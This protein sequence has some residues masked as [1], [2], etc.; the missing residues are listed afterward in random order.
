MVIFTWDRA[1]REILK[2]KVLGAQLSPRKKKQ[3]K[4]NPTRSDVEAAVA[5]FLADGGRIRKVE[6]FVAGVDNVI[7]KEINH[8]EK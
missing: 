7:E 3:P 1:E 5:S 4:F 8:A 6:S 2:S